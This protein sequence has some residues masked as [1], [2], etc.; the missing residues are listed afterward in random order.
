MISD[1]AD[2]AHEATPRRS[3]QRTADAPHAQRRDVFHR[4]FAGRANNQIDRH[5]RGGSDDGGN[6]LARA[7]TRRIQHVRTRPR[8]GLMPGQRCLRGPDAR[9]ISSWPA[10]PAACPSPIDQWPRTPPG[11]A[12]P[13]RR[14]HAADSP[15]RPSRLQSTALPRRFQSPAEHSPRRPAGRRQIHFRR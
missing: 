6:L 11:A 7:N 1:A 5:R 10:P 8:I 4:Q 13:P 3:R 15:H 14:C 9:R 2:R 12:P